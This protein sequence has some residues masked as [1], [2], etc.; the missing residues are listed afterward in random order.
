MQSRG[1]EIVVGFFVCLGIAAVFILTMRVSDL[2][3]T[4]GIE[5]YTVTAAFS[6]VGGLKAGAPVQLAGV[7]IGRV[8]DIR[9]DNTTYEAVVSMRIREGYELPEDS[10]AQ[11]LTAGLLG[12]QYVGIGPGA[13]RE[14]LAD[15]DRIKITQGAVILEELIGQFLYQMGNRGGE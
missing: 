3:D 4:G 6:N 13:A 12:E 1:L 14:S 9:I 11:I 7:R 5:G 8:T 15:G 2:A 10:D